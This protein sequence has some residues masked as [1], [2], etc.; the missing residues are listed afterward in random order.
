MFPHK[1]ACKVVYG[2]FY[3]FRKYSKFEPNIQTLSYTLTLAHTHRYFEISQKL[4][5]ATKG[6]CK[7][8]QVI[9]IKEK[10]FSHSIL[11][12]CC[13]ADDSSCPM[14]FIL[15]STNTSLINET[16]LSDWTKACVYAYGTHGTLQSFPIFTYL[17]LKSNT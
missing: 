16:L 6:N 1:I 17:K 4:H 8:H 10:R 5:S 14:N 7:T 9:C 12:H 2:P 11:E 3:I 15:P 13:L